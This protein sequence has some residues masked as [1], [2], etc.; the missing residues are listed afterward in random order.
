MSAVK[1]H[2]IDGVKLTNGKQAYGSREMS[3]WL[4]LFIRY[5]REIHKI[6]LVITKVADLAPTAKSASTHVGGY[7][8]DTRTWNLTTAQQRKVVYEGTRLGMPNHRRYRSQGFD[9]HNHGM[10]DVGYTTNCSYQI[11]RTRNG[12]DGLARNGVD[13]DKAYR[14]KQP[15]MGWKAGVETMQR[16]LNPPKIT[17]IPRHITRKPWM[18]IPVNG[19][20]SGLTLSRIQ[21]Q[22]QIRPTG[23]LDHYTVRALKHW[24]DPTGR[25]GGGDDGTGILRRIDVLL[26]QYRVNSLQDGDWGPGTTRSFQRYLNSH[27]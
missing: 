10:L 17:P 22:L 2:R 11:T 1:L 4:P 13:L 8:V 6:N 18:E 21:W 19:L 23:V 14:P 20:M 9:P 25:A 15:W 16:E 27:R 3:I 5:L 7:A 24:L 26:L 12:R